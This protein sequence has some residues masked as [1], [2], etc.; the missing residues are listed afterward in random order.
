VRT[1][2]AGAFER[3][4]QSENAAYEHL[5]AVKGSALHVDGENWGKTSEWKRTYESVLSHTMNH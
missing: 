1:E 2:Q 3:F 5:G 4:L